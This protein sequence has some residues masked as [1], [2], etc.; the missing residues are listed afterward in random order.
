MVI[1]NNITSENI[2]IVKELINNWQIASTL[3]KKK[4]K[5]FEKYGSTW[6]DSQPD[7]TRNPIDPFKNDPFWPVTRLTCKPDWPDPTCLFC[8][9]YPKVKQNNYGRGRKALD[10]RIYSR[11]LLPWMDCQCCHGKKVQRK[12]EMC[13]DFTDL[14]NACPKDSFTLS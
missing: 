1:D 12:A 9:V 2:I 4:K 14:N 8:H 7:S 13:M 6:P 5:L 10:F 3:K 11:G